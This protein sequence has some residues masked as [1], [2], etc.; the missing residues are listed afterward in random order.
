MVTEIACIDREY[1]NVLN[2]TC[3]VCNWMDSQGWIFEYGLFDFQRKV[4]DGFV[5][6]AAQLMDANGNFTELGQIYVNQQPMELPRQAVASLVANDEAHTATG[7][8]VRAMASTELNIAHQEIHAAANFTVTATL[9]PN[10]QE[11]L[12]AHNSKRKAK[13]LNPLAWDKQFENDALAYARHLARIEKLE[14]S[15]GDSRSNQGENLAW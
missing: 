1:Q 11:V 14:H 2:F 15:S 8:A 9:G 6:P 7:G 4:A 12:D 10:K 5:S 3:K 13:G